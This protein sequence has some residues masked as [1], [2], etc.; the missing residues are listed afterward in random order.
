DD[1]LYRIIGIS[2]DWRPTPEFYDL[3]ATTRN[4]TYGG[5]DELFIPFTS[6]VDA[7][8]QPSEGYGCDSRGPGKGWSGILH[9]NCIWISFWAQLPT[10]AA[11]A[12][13]RNYLLNYAA[14]QR[15]IGRFNW[16]PRVALQD[17]MAWLRYNHIVPPAVDTL[18][19]MSFAILGVCLLNATGL[20]LAKFMSR[21]GN[22]G[23]RRALGASR[24]AVFFQCLVEAGTIGGVGALA[25]LALTALG[26]ITCRLVMPPDL[27]RLARADAVDVVIA[28]AMALAGSVLAGLYPTWRV[29]RV[30]S[31]PQLKTL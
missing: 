3:S 16:P 10:A 2:R 12:E 26:L 18:T 9:A 24:P 14:R 28:V 29:A 19:G 8:F 4:A 17:V 11:A 13:Y 6:A 25:G 27:A 1:R 22:V 23:V 20:M 30:R 5:S 21:S 15:E 31:V 7:A